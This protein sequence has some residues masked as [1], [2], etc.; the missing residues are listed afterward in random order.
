MSNFSQLTPDNK[1][2]KTL[3]ELIKLTVFQDEKL[4]SLFTLIS[5]AEHGKKLAFIG[6]MEDVGRKLTSYC[7]PDYL[8]ANI[9]AQEKNWAIG[10]WEIPLE[11]C[12]GDIKGTIAEYTLK[13]G[14]NIGDLTSNDYLTQVY[15]PALEDAI[16]KMFWRQVWF[17]DTTAQNVADGG[18]ITDGVDVDLFKTNDG[19]WKKLFEITTSK[20]AQKTTISANQEASFAG[21]RSALRVKGVA[22]G[23]VDSLIM[24]ADPRI[25]TME[26]SAIF[27]TKSLAD[28]LAQDVKATYNTIMPWE[29]VFS[30]VQA[31]EYNG[32]RIYA[33]SA[34][35]RMIQKYQNDGTKLHVPHRAVYT[36]PK[37]L[38]VGSQSNLVGEL[39]IW[40]NKDERV[41]RIYSAGDLGTL[42]AED[43]LV[44]VAC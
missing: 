29:V 22:T 26:D 19:L 42:I 30:G 36:S 11:L 23:I 37:N 28:A 7:N 34:W 2:V 38:L 8:N 31:T 18:F 1:A 32:V 44:Q 10:E 9:S 20:S 17:G 21:Q 43:D 25:S 6:E 39:D 33:I 5:N 40:F 27:M 12:Y 14:T 4:E 41:T 16:R 3:Q 24:D 15:R 13:A 35:D